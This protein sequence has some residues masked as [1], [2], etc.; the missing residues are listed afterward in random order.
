[1]LEEAYFVQFLSKLFLFFLSYVLEGRSVRSEVETN[2]LHDALT[3][4]NVAAEMADD[5]DDLLRI[6]L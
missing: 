5:I 4:H 2:Q 3:T 6:I 1:M